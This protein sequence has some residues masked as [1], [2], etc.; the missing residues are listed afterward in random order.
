MRLAVIP[1]RSGIPLGKSNSVFPQQ[2]LF[3]GGRRLVEAGKCYPLNIA[4]KAKPDNSMS[5]FVAQHRA[6]LIE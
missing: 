5:E 3:G 4:A 2:I 6:V 1:R